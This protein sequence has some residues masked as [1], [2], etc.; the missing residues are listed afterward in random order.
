MKP[1]H[2]KKWRSRQSELVTKAVAALGLKE[3]FN[4][5]RLLAI[6]KGKGFVGRL[7]PRMSVEQ[8]SARLHG[9]LDDQK[10]SKR[11]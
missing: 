9:R 10:N 11:H 8:V 2:Q 6:N 3:S 1:E 5:V 4:L 7:L